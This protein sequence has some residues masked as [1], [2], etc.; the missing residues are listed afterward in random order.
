MREIKF[1]GLDANGSW[2][3]GDVYFGVDNLRAHIH[4]TMG[5]NVSI[6]VEV[7]T[8]G[9]LTGLLDKEGVD[10]YEGDILK[11]HC[12]Q[13]DYFKTDVLTVC[14]LDGCFCVETKR[15]ATCLHEMVGP[16]KQEIFLEIIGNIHQKTLNS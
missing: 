1:R 6:E 2:V 8:I 10:I 15:R 11:D 3:F 7:E 5:S 4:P 12:G 13:T 9:Q 14:F 16:D